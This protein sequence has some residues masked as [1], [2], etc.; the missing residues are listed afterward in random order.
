MRISPTGNK[1]PG[2]WGAF[3]LIELLVVLGILSVILFLVAPNLASF[4]NP[5]RTRSFA[6]ELQSRLVY[7]SEKAVLEK[8]VL[9]FNFDLD[10]RVYS[11][12][13][14]AQEEGEGE[15]ETLVRDRNLPATPF[16]EN[17]EVLRVEVIP[18][19]AVFGGNMVVPLTPTGM[20][21][22]FAIVMR[23]DRER[24]LVLSGDSFNG[25]IELRV[26]FLR[27]AALNRGA[28]P[29]RTAGG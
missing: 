26:E 15:E 16:P 1:L 14:P 2:R 20:M 11:F 9:L 4:V 12:T 5:A 17:L 25:K 23:E 19:D 21:L 29:R 13:L 7:A 22:G 6:R 24:V 28:A 18:G 10:E 27:A 8:R 3:T